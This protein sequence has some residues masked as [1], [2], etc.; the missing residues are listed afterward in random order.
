MQHCTTYTNCVEFKVVLKEAAVQLK[1]SK[2]SRVKELALF[3]LEK[4]KTWREL[5][6]VFQFVK[7][8]SPLQ[9]E[10]NSWSLFPLRI[11]YNSMVL[12]AVHED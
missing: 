2:E 8:H 6:T 9:V 3:S 7:E 11:V 10:V 1:S 5:I 4:K 12:N